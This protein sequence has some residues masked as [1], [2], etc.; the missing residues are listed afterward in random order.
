ME[1]RFVVLKNLEGAVGRAVVA[2]EHVEVAGGLAQQGIEHRGK[3]ILAVPNSQNDITGAHRART[4]VQPFP[5]GQLRLPNG[6]VARNQ[7]CKP[8]KNVA[9]VCEQDSGDLQ[10]GCAGQVAIIS[11]VVHRHRHAAQFEATT[12][13]EAR[14]R[15]KV[16][17]PV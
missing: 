13:Q 2:H 9:P 14:L 7:P 6:I 8:A 5:E 4:S 3:I 10:G 15:A 11:C 17:L 12:S 16:A 1:L